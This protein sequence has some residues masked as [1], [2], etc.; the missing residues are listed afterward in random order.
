MALDQ[1]IS[2][3][4]LDQ[5]ISVRLFFIVMVP[6]SCHFLMKM[7]LVK[8]GVSFLATADIMKRTCCFGV[9]IYMGYIVTC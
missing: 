3:R 6:G 7:D 8:T 9:I 4:P 5:I 1:I 2:V